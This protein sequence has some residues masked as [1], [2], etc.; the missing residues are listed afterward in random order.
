MFRAS[1]AGLMRSDVRF[2]ACPE[3]HR[4]CCLDL[5]GHALRP[6][7]LDRV[8][9]ERPL[10]SEHPSAF[11]RLGQGPGVIGAE[12]GLPQPAADAVSESPARG[13]ELADLQVEAAAVAGVSGLC[14]PHDLPNL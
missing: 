6:P 14:C 4:R 13:P 11:A 8:F 12:P 2:G 9:T 1:P 10:L 5:R 3:A 7:L